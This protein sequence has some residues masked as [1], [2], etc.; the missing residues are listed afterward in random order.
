MAMAVEYEKIKN[1]KDRPKGVFS[2]FWRTFYA[3]WIRQWLNPS[4]STTVKD[5]ETSD[6]NQTNADEED[7]PSDSE[8]IPATEENG[9]KLI[10][11]T[12]KPKGP[13]TVRKVSKHQIDYTSNAH[14]YAETKTMDQQSYTTRKKREQNGEAGFVGED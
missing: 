11:K 3:E 8:A 4:L 7:V 6:D 2:T 13:L 5:E 1:A 9:E 10:V 14:M 12:T